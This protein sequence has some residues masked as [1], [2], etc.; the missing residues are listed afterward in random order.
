MYNERHNQL[1]SKRAMR[2][3]STSEWNEILEL[4]KAYLL[5]IG[6]KLSD[7]NVDTFTKKP[8]HKIYVAP[9]N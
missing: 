9:R 7:W 6:E 5:S 1:E 8:P 3:L 4:R 2:G